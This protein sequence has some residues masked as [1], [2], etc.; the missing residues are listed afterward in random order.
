[1]GTEDLSS[2]EEQRSSVLPI[3]SQDVMDMMMGG[4]ELKRKLLIHF[5]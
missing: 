4:M 5:K 1:M 3:I 2:Q